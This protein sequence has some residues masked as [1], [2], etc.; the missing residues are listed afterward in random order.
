MGNNEKDLLIVVCNFANEQRKTYRIGVPLPGKYK[1][2]LNS[3]AKKFGGKGFVNVRGIFSEEQEWDMK[4]QSIAFKM[5]ALSVQV[6]SY[7]PFTAKEKALI[8][9]KKAEERQRQNE[10]K[11]LADATEKEKIARQ[12]ADEAREHAR[13]A[14]EEA[15]LALKRAMEEAKRAEELEREAAALEKKA[16][17]AQAARE[18]VKETAKF[19]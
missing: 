12:L 16:K 4:E 8:E 1:E 19:L 2:I 15:K 5:P 18:H 6:F 11:K 10:L 7:T 14:Q 3:D 9:Q 13:I 17:K